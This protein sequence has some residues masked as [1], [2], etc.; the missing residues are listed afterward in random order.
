MRQIDLMIVGAQK[1]ATTSLKNYLGKHPSLITHNLTEFAFFANDEEYLEGFEHAFKKYFPETFSH[2][3]KKIIAKNASLYE[4]E[5][6]LTRLYEHNPDCLIVLIIRNPIERA[7]SSYN[8]ERE[9]GWYTKPWSAISTSLT[10]FSKGEKDQMF[11]LFIELGLYSEHLKKILRFFP[12]QQV[13]IILF[14]ELKSDPSAVCA[15]LFRRLE[16]N[17]S[18]VVDTTVIHNP[19]KKA[20]SKKMGRFLIWLMNNENPL[21]IIAKKI[22]PTKTFL[23]IRDWLF[24]ANTGDTIAK[25]PPMSPEI[26]G[27][28]TAFFKPYNDELQMMTGLKL[29]HWNE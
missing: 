15:R 16:V 3:A 22:L 29:G 9:S 23:K 4:N 13:Q 17:D 5:E 12:K 25:L 27:E 10:N 11:R 8:M 20:R 28:L 14:D 6:A 7:Y 24:K 19:T 18:I 1:A 21:K 2:S 26:L